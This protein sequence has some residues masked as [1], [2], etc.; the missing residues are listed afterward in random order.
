MVLLWL[1]LLSMSYGGESGLMPWV[2]AGVVLYGMAFIAIAAV[3][4]MPGIVWA[5]HLAR[6]APASWRK[7]AKV[8]GWIGTTSLSVGLLVSV[9]VLVAEQFRPKTETATCVSWRDAAAS[10]ALANSGGE[11]LPDCPSPK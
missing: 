3:V 11:S 10:E 4:G 5:R 1:L 7:T 2:A 9:A 6:V 8:A